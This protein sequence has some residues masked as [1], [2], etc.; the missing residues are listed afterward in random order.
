[1]TLILQIYLFFSAFCIDLYATALL[2]FFLTLFCFWKVKRKLL[3]T[4]LFLIAL[5]PVSVIE[6][7]YNSANLNNKAQAGEYTNLNI[8]GVY[9]LTFIMSSLGALSGYP[10]TGF[11]MMYFALPSSVKSKEISINSNYAMESEK[12]RKYIKKHIISKK[13][14]SSYHLNW[15]R[16]EHSTDSSRVALSLNGASKLFVYTKKDENGKIHYDCLIKTN[17]H[18]NDIGTSMKV[19][20]YTILRIEE[21]VFS[22]M[23]KID[24]FTPYVINWRWKINNLS[25]VR[26][27]DLFWIDDL[28]EK[29]MKASKK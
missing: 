22:G 10:E 12:V 28:I 19:G 8:I 7:N 16:S 20:G 11:E 1:M 17:F 6:W 13:K 27:Y 2:W 3:W 9:N 23:Q 26:Y 5:V 25:D 15:T 21:G 14:I 4:M 18:M 24:A 29:T